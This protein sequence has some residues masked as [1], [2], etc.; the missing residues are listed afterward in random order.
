MSEGNA[1][2]TL[3]GYI[4]GWLSVGGDPRSSGSKLVKLA[5][6]SYD[7]KYGTKHDV[8]KTTKA[9]KNGTLT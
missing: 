2:I 5:I 9:F 6:S 7:T 4:R 3:K 8:V 1:K